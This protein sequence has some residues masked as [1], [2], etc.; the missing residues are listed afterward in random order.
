M[1]QYS[2]F[3][4]KDFSHLTIFR[5]SEILSFPEDQYEHANV[6]PEEKKLRVNVTLLDFLCVANL[7]LSGNKE[8]TSNLSWIEIIPG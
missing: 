8:N 3:G 7:K 4:S 2:I 6:A 1:N 5:Q